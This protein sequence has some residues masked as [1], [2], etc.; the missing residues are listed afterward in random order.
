MQVPV[1]VEEDKISGS[2]VVKKTL[3]NTV[4]M[5]LTDAVNLLKKL[6]F[7]VDI[8]GDGTK[9][10]VQLPAA[11]GSY[12]QR[13]KVVLYTSIPAVGESPETVAVPDLTGKTI[14]EAIELTKMLNL[15]F[16]VQGSGKVIRQEPVPGTQIPIGD[17]IIV[18]MEPESQTAMEQFGP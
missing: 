17:K 8:I 11:G 6:E 3:P 1:Q 14:G 18:I 4:D 10:K 13:S 16:E 5:N 9:V 15:N 12:Q 2:G 7:K